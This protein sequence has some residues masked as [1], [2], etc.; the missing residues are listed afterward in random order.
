MVMD[1]DVGYIDFIGELRALEK[2]EIVA[3]LFDTKNAVKAAHNEFG[4][5]RVP[6][7][8]FLRSAMS[9]S[10]DEAVDLFAETAK[11]SE[12][13]RAGAA[14]AVFLKNKIRDKIRNGSFTPN[15]PSTVKRKGF[16]KP[17]IDTGE[18]LTAVKGKVRSRNE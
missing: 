14:V 10:E 5:S 13:E 9:E 3:G 1:R 7:R 11:R 17:L 4:N 6:Q 12:F 2:S 18:M 16:D 15:A 8:S